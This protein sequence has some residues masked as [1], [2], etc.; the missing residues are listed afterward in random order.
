MMAGTVIGGRFASWRSTAS[1]RGSPFAPRLRWRYEWITQSTK[2]GLSNDPAVCSYVASENVHVG[3]HCCQRSLQR[4][5]RFCVSPSRPRSVLKYH[6]YQK[7][8]ST[9]GAN[10]RGGEKTS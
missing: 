3:D 9:R 10:G 8:A 7:A 6:W 1:N 5:R 4:S 2:S